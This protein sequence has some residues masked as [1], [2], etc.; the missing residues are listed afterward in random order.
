MRALEGIISHFT[1]EIVSARLPITDANKTQQSICQNICITLKWWKLERLSDTGSGI[2]RSRAV[3]TWLT[4][5][6]QRIR[7]DEERRTGIIR[8]AVVRK[9]QSDSNKVAATGLLPRTAWLI[10]TKVW[11]RIIL[12]SRHAYRLITQVFVILRPCSTYP[13]MALI[14]SFSS[15]STMPLDKMVPNNWS[16]LCSLLKPSLSSSS[17]LTSN[18]FIS[19]PGFKLSARLFSGCCISSEPLTTCCE[20]PVVYLATAPTSPT[21]GPGSVFPPQSVVSTA[22]TWHH[23]NV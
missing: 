22:T 17:L 2:I 12:W 3:M 14:K 19:F 23:N 10:Q 11:T 4:V 7:K 6:K 18:H 13:V 5:A 15:W 16:N 21:T 9:S 8:N 1:G 20:S